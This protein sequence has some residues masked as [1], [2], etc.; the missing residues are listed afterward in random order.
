MI[1]GDILTKNLTRNEFIICDW[2]S[3]IQDIDLKWTAKIIDNEEIFAPYFDY[4]RLKNEKGEWDLA[5]S[6]KRPTYYFNDWLKRDDIDELPKDILKKFI[7]LYI[8]D[9][10]YYLDCEFLI[11][12]ETLRKLSY[13]KFVDKIVFLS[14]AP[15][16][17]ETDPRKLIMME[18][19]FKDNL[20]KFSLNVIHGNIP[21]S[22]FINENYPNYTVFI[23]DR[24][25]IIRDVINNTD[26][27]NKQF[28]FP[29]CGYNM[30]LGKDQKYIEECYNKGMIIS[31]YK[32]EIFK[33]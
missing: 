20:G 29:C 30:E 8:D 1:T 28:I 2:D 23:D 7:S 17:Y 27:A 5:L 4:S 22:K 10:L 12:A 14:S 3:V 21:K 13:E 19:F 16:D 18:R 25:D 9:P 32:Q 31:T 33:G 26:S 11:M 6:W 15:K 24:S